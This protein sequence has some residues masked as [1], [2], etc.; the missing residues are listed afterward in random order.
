MTRFLFMAFSAII[1]LIFFATFL[2]LIGFVAGLW[3]L[4][5]HVDHG[6]AVPLM[7]ALTIDNALI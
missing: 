2:Y 4:P 3:F 1:Y 7:A 5:S 6:P